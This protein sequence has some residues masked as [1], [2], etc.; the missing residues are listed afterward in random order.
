MSMC[1]QEKEGKRERESERDKE[2]EREGSRE[3]EREAVLCLFQRKEGRRGM[4]QSFPKS[5]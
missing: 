5:S 4:I 2:R 3:R 1:L